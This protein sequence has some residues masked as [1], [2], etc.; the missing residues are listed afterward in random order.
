MAAT[1]HNIQTTAHTIAF[2]DQTTGE[3]SISYDHSTE[4]LSISGTNSVNFDVDVDMAAGLDVAGNITMTG[5]TVATQSWVSSQ[6]YLTSETDD[7]TLNEVLTQGNSSELGIDVGPITGDSLKVG[8]GT[9]NS[10]LFY[11]E[12]QYNTTKFYGVSD[13]TASGIWEFKNTGPWNQTRF[14]IEDANNSSSR[15]TLDV[16]GNAGA[17]DILAAT[18][19]GN[20]G[21]GTTSPSSKLHVGDGTADD[22]VKVFFSDNTNLDI[23]GYGIEF[24]RSV[25]YLRPTTNA[26]KTLTVGTNT[27][28][29]N[30][31]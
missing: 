23:H 1:G 25:S 15:L 3:A 26:N 28:N 16:K 31:I 19:H 29:F 6:N 14:Y 30:K 11:S 12:G 22:F 4:I 24:N 27:R 7:Q 20:V 13:Q 21:I 2:R 8:D 5:A 9:A 10:L 18:S 17:I